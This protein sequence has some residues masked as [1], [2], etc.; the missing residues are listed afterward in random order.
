MNH[1]P[2]YPYFY[3]AHT[4]SF[5]RSNAGTMPDTLLER[6]KGEAGAIRLFS[7][8]V[9]LAPNQAQRNRLLEVLKDEQEH[10]QQL[11]NQYIGIT[12]SHPYYEVEEV[13]FTT[14]L[15]GIQRAFELK[16]NHYEEYRNDYL[17]TQPSPIRDLFLLNFNDE[18]KHVQELENLRLSR[19]EE[20]SDY[21]MQPFVVNIEEATK[22]NNAFRR[23]LWTGRHFQVTLMRLKVGEDIGLE[24]HPDVDQFLRIEQGQGIVQMGDREDQLSFQREVFDDYAIIIPAGKWHNLTNTG[25]VPLKL[26]SIYAPPEHPFGTVHETKAEA[27]AAQHAHH[28]GSF[29][30]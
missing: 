2:S 1:L 26:Y 20:T 9:E 7:T 8:L 15:E 19:N 14:F 10:L 25:N 4:P 18:A 16:C 5:Y 6:I 23:A 28:G 11:T 12:G 29:S 27:M 13:P 21:G 3:Y 24:M 30:Y 17:F 22:L